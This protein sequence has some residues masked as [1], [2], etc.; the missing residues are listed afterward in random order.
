M[1]INGPNGNFANVTDEN[2]LSVD[3]VMEPEFLHYNDGKATA[4]VWDF[5]S[6]YTAANSDTIMFI[7]NNSDS[8]LH[9]HHIYVFC[10]SAST[11][12]LH[13]PANPTASGTEVTG[14]NLNLTSGNVAEASAYQDEEGNSPGNT[15]HTEYIAANSPLTLLKEDGYEIILGKNDCLAIDVGSGDAPTTYGHIVG[16][17]HD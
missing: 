10:S 6:G 9:I 14:R 13:T 17:F 8:T 7:R 12:T 11:L 15:L 3:G 1:Q 4:Y 16:Y 2:K 5:P